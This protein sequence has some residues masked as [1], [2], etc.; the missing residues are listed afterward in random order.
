IAGRPDQD[1][2]TAIR[3]DHVPSVRTGVI[4]AIVP[5][6][7]IA[8]TADRGLTAATED[9]DRIAATAGPGPTGATR[10]TVL[11]A[12]GAPA[13]RRPPTVAA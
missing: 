3:A 8:V 1:A 9:R 2:R 6:G 13:P 7:R 12:T 5:T 10:A 4:A 11:T